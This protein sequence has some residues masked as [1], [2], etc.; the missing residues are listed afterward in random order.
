MTEETKTAEPSE[1][2][3]ARTL[4][5]EHGR[6]TRRFKVKVSDII[7][8]A[9]I[10][11]VIVGMTIFIV[12]RLSLKHE[13]SQAQPV[14]DKVVTALSKQDTQSL[15]MLGDKSFQAKNSAESLNAHLTATNTDGKPITFAQLYGKSKPVLD[16]QIVAN[17]TRGQHVVFVYKYT[18]LK[19]PLYVRIDTV[20]PSHQSKWYLQALTVG[21]DEAAMTSASQ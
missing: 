12:H 10:A 16:T 4:A 7:I 18:R 13:V 14:A 3:E 19:A 20:E 17:N 9:V 6:K 2:T 15:R 1:T 11:A 8:F 5:P 21:T